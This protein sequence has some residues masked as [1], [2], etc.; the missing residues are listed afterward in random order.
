MN[1][2]SQ[3]D[4]LFG[5][6]RNPTLSNGSVR[7]AS[8]ANLQSINRKSS[9]LFDEDD[10]CKKAGELEERERIFDLL[11]YYNIYREKIEG[12]IKDNNEIF[13]EEAGK[14]SSLFIPSYYRLNRYP[15]KIQI[16]EAC[17][18]DIPAIADIIFIKK[19]T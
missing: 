4:A 7:T 6:T 3:K 13:E 11:S 9:F 18:D 5:K 10:V 15:R 8:L 1:I 17:L 19:K 2:Y 16:R 14:E 12:V